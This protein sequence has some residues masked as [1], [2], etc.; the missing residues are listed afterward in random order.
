M[1]YDPSRKNLYYAIK[2]KGAFKN[3]S[4]FKVDKNNNYLTYVTDK[5]LSETPKTSEIVEILN[6][7]LNEL[8]LEHYQE[9]SGSGAVLNAILVAENHPACMLKFA[10]TEK[11]GGSIWDFA[12]T[13]CIF[14]EL[15]L[16]ATD[17]QGHKLDLNRK[18]STFMNEKG[19]YFSNF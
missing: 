17:F 1:V 4:S 6:Q 9:I 12:A 3:D 14:K 15:G 5:K 2:G 11:G 19:I 7:K 16:T 18:E 13:A 8:G 10:K